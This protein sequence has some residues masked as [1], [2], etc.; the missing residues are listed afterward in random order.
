[1][2]TTEYSDQLAQHY[3]ICYQGLSLIEREAFMARL[4]YAKRFWEPSRDRD[5]CH[6]ASIAITNAAHRVTEQGGGDSRSQARPGAPLE[7]LSLLL[8]CTVCDARLTAAWLRLD[9]IDASRA[10]AV[11]CHE[12][13][14]LAQ[15]DRAV[16]ERLARSFGL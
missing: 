3:F 4:E 7:H 13:L 6:L 2:T 15:S 1:M 12:A 14:R 8:G 9:G 11:I 16:S 5:A 10:S